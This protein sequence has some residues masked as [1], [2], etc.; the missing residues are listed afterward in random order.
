MPFLPAALLGIAAAFLAAA[1]AAFL[2]ALRSALASGGATDSL[3]RWLAAPLVAR[4]RAALRRQLPGALV[5][6]ATSVRAGL[7]LPQALQGAAR[8][9][10]EPAGGE[11][12]RLVAEVGQG[13]TLEVALDRF[14]ARNPGPE[15][16]LLTA[17]LK[18]ARATGGGLA[19]LLEQLAATLRDRERL[20]GQVRA[21]TAQGRLS[22]WV[23]GATPLVLL[24]AMW[25]IAPEFLRPLFT[26]PAGWLLLGVAAVLE[27][28]GAL[29]I[30]AAV[31]VE[32]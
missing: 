14:A 23:V 17:G 32:P 12:R 16:A 27:L 10:A 1:F 9:Q 6:L 26:M 28:L 18:L 20:R 31:R 19:P 8:S 5:S 29:G 11:L 4:R 24:A 30:R 15:T 22:G 25:L 21:L 3:P 2:P 13:A 7:S